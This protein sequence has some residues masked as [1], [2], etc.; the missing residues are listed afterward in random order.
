M[1][2]PGVKMLSAFF[3]PTLAKAAKDGAPPVWKRRAIHEKIKIRIA[4]M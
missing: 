1:E 2:A 3:L 4:Q